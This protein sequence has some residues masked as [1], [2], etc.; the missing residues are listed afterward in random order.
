M[1]TA[2][3]P[4]KQYLCFSLLLSLNC[5]L[6][7]F[8]PTEHMLSIQLSMFKFSNEIRHL[9][10]SRYMFQ[11]SLREHILSF[12]LLK[13]TFSNKVRHQSQ[14]WKFGAQFKLLLTVLKV[15]YHHSV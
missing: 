13:F 3:H 15:I 1:E 5:K 14:S 10:H 8:S 11:F 6:L 2:K 7:Q 4:G 9:S 12:Q